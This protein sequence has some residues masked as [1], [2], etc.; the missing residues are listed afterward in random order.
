MLEEDK[1]KF[2]LRIF[3]APVD[4]TTQVYLFKILD[5]NPSANELYLMNTLLSWAERYKIKKLQVD[6]LLTRNSNPA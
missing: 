6:T 5:S 2:E 4:Q 1:R 3:K